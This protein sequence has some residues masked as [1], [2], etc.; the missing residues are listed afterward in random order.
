MMAAFMHTNVPD[1]ARLVEPFAVACHGRPAAED[2]D[3]PCARRSHEFKDGWPVSDC[4]RIGESAFTPRIWLNSRRPTRAQ[5]SIGAPASEAD[6]CDLARSCEIPHCKSKASRGLAARMKD[7]YIAVNGVTRTVARLLAAA[8]LC[9]MLAGSTPAIA[10]PTPATAASA[11]DSACASGDAVQC[12][13]LGVSYIH[14]YGV[15]A[16]PQRAFR[17]FARACSTG[18]A[19]GCSNLGALYESGVGVAE[20]ASQAAQMYERACNAGNALGCSNLGALYARGRGVERNVVQAQR[21]FL[22]AC[23]NG[24]AAGC[25]NLIQYSASR[26]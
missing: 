18:S 1:D 3:G 6:R 15:P 5:R 21:L 16:D 19:D 4:S 10:D 22:L 11:L 8:T 20:N 12:N 26:S 7:T 25:N 24:S 9:V 2:A 13:D 14:G 23:E 17:A